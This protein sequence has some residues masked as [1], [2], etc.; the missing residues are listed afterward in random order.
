MLVEYPDAKTDKTGR[1]EWPLLIHY[2]LSILV[3]G[4]AGKAILL[5]KLCDYRPQ[6]LHRLHWRICIVQL[7]SAQVLFIMELSYYKS[8]LVNLGSYFRESKLLIWTS[9]SMTL[10]IFIFHLWGLLEFGSF[11]SFYMKYG[12]VAYFT[13]EEQID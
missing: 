7:L 1:K 6:R 3:P 8:F 4:I 11:I 2:I 9:L 13:R 5:F 10:H 12:G